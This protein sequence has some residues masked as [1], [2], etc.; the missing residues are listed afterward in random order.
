M[1][2]DPLSVSQALALA[3]GALEQVSATIVGEVSE[4]SDKPGYKAVYFTLSDKSAALP[5]LCWRSVFDRFGIELRQGMLIEVAG[6]FSVY[7]A[8]GRMNFDVRGMRLA[9]EGELRLK[10][11]QRARKLESEGLMDP[12]RKLP[13][14]ALPSRIAVVTS[15]R[16]KAIHDVLRTLR[17][18]YPL[19]EVLVAGV[20]VEGE[21]AAASIIEGL[22]VAEASGAQIILLVRGGGSY[23]DLMPFNDEQLAR[24]IVAA[25]VPIVTGIGHEPD[26][27]IADMVAS[28]RASTPT[29]AA[30]HVAPAITELAAR[31]D[32]LEGRLRRALTGKVAHLEQ[33]L[34]HYTER[35]LFRDAHY[36]IGTQ[37]L[38]LE[39]AG[40]RLQRALPGLL[41]HATFTNDKLASRLRLVGSG[42]LTPFHASAQLYAAQLEG[43]SPLK[44]LA[45]GYSVTYSASGQVVD[46]LDKVNLGDTVKVRVQDGSLACTVDEKHEGACI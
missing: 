19:A 43:L 23:E 20:P 40:E 10:V 18:R 4:Y 38:S 1:A 11:A 9:G 37:Q 6:I 44:V 34:I 3:K 39:A 8:K 21:G 12:A 27:S 29:A 41:A 25:Q 14:P 28:H 13:L 46:A 35:P 7:A 42:L 5:C 32:A 22:R 33:T 36:L 31:F 26:T 15:P 2:Q 24:A 17:R 45:R 16:G 30:E